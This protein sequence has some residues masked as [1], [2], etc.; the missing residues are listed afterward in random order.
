[1]INFQSSKPSKE[2]EASLSAERMDR[3]RKRK[4]GE[5]NE[6]EEGKRDRTVPEEE[7]E[8]FFAIL[9]RLRDAYLRRRQRDGEHAAAWWRPAFEMEDFQN[10]KVDPPISASDPIPRM[11]ID[12]NADPEP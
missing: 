2:R 3:N 9:Q 5:G 10:D 8:E 12:L 11:I 4:K 6:R 1:M 7:V